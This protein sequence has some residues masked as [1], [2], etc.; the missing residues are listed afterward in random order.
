MDAHDCRPRPRRRGKLRLPALLRR[1]IGFV[2]LMALRFVIT[3]AQRYNDSWLSSAASSC[4]VATAEHCMPDKS[5]QSVWLPLVRY[6]EEIPDIQAK[7]P[8]RQGTT[9]GCQ[10]GSSPGSQLAK[11]LIARIAVNVNTF[12]V[13]ASKNF[14]IHEQQAPRGLLIEHLGTAGCYRAT[15]PP[16]LRH[17][18]SHLHAHRPYRQ[19]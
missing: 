3:F 6:G 8:Q 5:V 15:R 12:C 19:V 13:N 17:S 10:A 7:D 11:P 4:S 1:Q 9:M 2:M 18:E 14:H 16:S